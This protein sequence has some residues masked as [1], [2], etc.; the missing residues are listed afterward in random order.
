[1]FCLSQWV[2]TWCLRHQAVT[3]PQGKRA[4]R[5]PGGSILKP[6]R[7]EWIR[8]SSR[9][10]IRTTT[11]GKC[12][13]KK[14][15]YSL[16]RCSGIILRVV[17][18]PGSRCSPPGLVWGLWGCKA[19]PGTQE[20]GV[21]LVLPYSSWAWASASGPTRSAAGWFCRQNRTGQVEK[22]NGW[23]FNLNMVSARFK[24]SNWNCTRFSTSSFTILRWGF[25]HFIH[26]LG[27]IT[28]WTLSLKALT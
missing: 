26:F 8:L 4:G 12:A 6:N 2:V 22:G 11:T 15:K 16:R 5:W 18:R 20:F 24:K 27:I 17:P 10:A 7:D 1:M 23:F 19:A 13:E 21:K 28:N 14:N 25:L 9:N 3:P